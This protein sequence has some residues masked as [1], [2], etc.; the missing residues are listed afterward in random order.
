MLLLLLPQQINQSVF[1][2]GHDVAHL[3]VLGTVAVSASLGGFGGLLFDGLG[4]GVQIVVGCDELVG[5]SW[6]VVQETLL[7]GLEALFTYVLDAQADGLTGDWRHTDVKSLR[8]HWAV[9]VIY[10]R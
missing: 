10:M 9:I 6:A 3:A 2:F 7:F 8:G 4:G 1:V 5:E